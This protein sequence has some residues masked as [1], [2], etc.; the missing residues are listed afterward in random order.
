[1]GNGYKVISTSDLIKKL[2]EYEALNG[3]GAIDSIGR[4]S[5][6][7]YSFN[8]FNNSEF[9]RYFGT[10]KDRNGFRKTKIKISPVEDDDLFPCHINT[11]DG[12]TIPCSEKTCQA[13]NEE[14]CSCMWK[15]NPSLLFKWHRDEKFAEGMCHRVKDLLIKH[16]S[17][18]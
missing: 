8:V 13:Y 10:E 4:D 17:E 18:K 3:V 7:G 1:M 9:N 11:K 12:D 2:Y 6:G 14:S 5:D 16:E 15:I